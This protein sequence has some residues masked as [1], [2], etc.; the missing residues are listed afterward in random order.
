MKLLRKLMARV[1]T[2][3]RNR[4][5]SVLRIFTWTYTAPDKFSFHSAFISGAHRI[6]NG[7]TFITEGATGRFF[8]ITQE[9]EMVWEYWNPY[10]ETT[11]LPTGKVATFPTGPF[12]YWQWRGT[13]IPAD[14]P[15][16]AGKNFRTNSTTTKSFC[17]PATPG[18]TG[19]W[20]LMI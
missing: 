11:L 9:G 10:K 17:T 12:M 3:C 7:N 1:I 20:I 15:A 4:L 16:V 6:A 19:W 8:E 2:Y 14:H 5:L 18:T 13:F